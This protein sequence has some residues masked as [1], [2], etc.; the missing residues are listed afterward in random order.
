MIYTVKIKDTF[1]LYYDIYHVFNFYLRPFCYKIN[2][3]TS[4]PKTEIKLTFQKEFAFLSSI[5]SKET[6][7]NFRTDN[8]RIKTIVRREASIPLEI[9]AAEAVSK[10]NKP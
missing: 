7:R 2:P 3:K 10:I 4:N 9:K 6:K 5:N 1:I 8:P